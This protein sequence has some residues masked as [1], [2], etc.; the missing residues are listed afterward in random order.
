MRMQLYY[1]NFEPVTPDNK[2]DV[3]RINAAQV[4]SDNGE[5]LVRVSR[6]NRVWFYTVTGDN[7]SH[8]VEDGDGSDDEFALEAM[9]RQVASAMGLPGGKIPE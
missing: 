9:R 3:S 1:G 6:V 5:I 2:V 7:R 4:L 8:I